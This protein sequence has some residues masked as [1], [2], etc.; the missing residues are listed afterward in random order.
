MG[1]GIQEREA[2]SIKVWEPGMSDK[3]T[4]VIAYYERNMLALM[5]AEGWYNDYIQT[6]EIEPHTNEPYVKP[7][8]AGWRR[9]LSLYG[10]AFTFHVPDDFDVM[11][12]PQIRCNW[13]GHS[14]QEKWTRV[15][16]VMENKWY[17]KPD[18]NHLDSLSGRS[19]LEGNPS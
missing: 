4:A 18:E 13:D 16:G 2:M 15:K 8:Y 14:T 3:E 7:R 11:N 9:V 12:L 17:R 6:G 5:M 10:G 1:R 19:E